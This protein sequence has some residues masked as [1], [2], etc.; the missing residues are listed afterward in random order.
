[1]PRWIAKGG[2][3]LLVVGLGAVFWGLAV[4]VEVM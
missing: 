3:V 2:W 1:V 4:V